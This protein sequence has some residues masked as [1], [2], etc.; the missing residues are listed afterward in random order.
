M[1]PVSPNAIRTWRRGEV[2]SGAKS[3]A[4]DAVLIAE[5]LR[6]RVHR[7]QPARTRT[8]LVVMP[9]GRR[10]DQPGELGLGH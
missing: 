1:V 3:D 6:L 5:Y 4:G 10:A 7:L 2:L 8:R 9:S